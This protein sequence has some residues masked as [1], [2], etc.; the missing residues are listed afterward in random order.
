MGDE[1]SDI[2][3]AFGKAMEDVDARKPQAT[4]Q[5]TGVAFAPGIGPF[6]ESKVVSFI[7]DEL[8]NDSRFREVAVG[9]SYPNAARQKCD[10]VVTTNHDTTWFIEVKR[11][12]LLG[13]NGKPNDNLLMHLLSPYPQHRS[14][15]TDCEKLRASGFQGH[16]AIILYAYDFDELPAETAI[17]TFEV[18]SQDLGSMGQ[19]VIASF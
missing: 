6:Q 7:A 15:L 1:L 18:L 14:A 16:K 12:Q 8:A 17:R 2:V 13:D 4:N 5:R 11:L 10:L 3:A 9:V 19:R